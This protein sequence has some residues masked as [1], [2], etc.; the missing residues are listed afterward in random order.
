MDLKGLM[1]KAKGVFQQR[2]GATAAKEDAQ[3]LRDISKEQGSATDKAKDAAAAIKDPGAPGPD[4]SGE[5]GA[6]GGGGQPADQQ[7]SP[8]AP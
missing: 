1:D 6:G 3:E 5:P 7:G 4:P 2:G 8:E